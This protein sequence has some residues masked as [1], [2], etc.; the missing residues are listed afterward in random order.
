[1]ELTGTDSSRNRPAREAARHE[2]PRRDD[3]VLALRQLRDLARRQ[4]VPHIDTNCR[5]DRHAP[6]LPGQS[7]RKCGC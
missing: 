2:L 7:A 5:L 4:F 1:M 6:T 3:P